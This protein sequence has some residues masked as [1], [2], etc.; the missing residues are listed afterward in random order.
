[1]SQGSSSS[2]V[3]GTADNNVCMHLLKLVAAELLDPEAL[4]FAHACYRLWRKH[5]RPTKAVPKP[6]PPP[7]PPVPPCGCYRHVADIYDAWNWSNKQVNYAYWDLKLCAS[8]FADVATE[9][10]AGSRYV[11]LP[12]GLAQGFT[13]L[14]GKIHVSLDPKIHRTGND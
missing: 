8:A 9:V 5:Y 14:H 13:M 11:Q 10:A 7:P 1:M 12:K 6:P 4:R 3:L 2:A